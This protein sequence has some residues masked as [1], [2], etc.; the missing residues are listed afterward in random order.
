MF[1]LSLVLIMSLYM[2]VQEVICIGFFVLKIFIWLIALQC[3]I[4]PFELMLTFASKTKCDISGE[5]LLVFGMIVALKEFNWC[6]PQPM[7]SS[8]LLTLSLPFFLIFLLL[9]SRSNV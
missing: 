3:F 1:L 9:Y 7:C 6:F 2:V 4:S 5:L 8:T